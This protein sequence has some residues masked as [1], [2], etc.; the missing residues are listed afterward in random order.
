MPGEVLLVG[1]ATIAVAVAGF[2]AVTSTL[3]PPGGAWSQ[4]MRLRQRAIVSTSFNVAFEALA[5]LIAFAWLDDERS[6]FVVASYGVAVYATG[7][8]VWRGR[9]FIHA[10]GLRTGAAGLVLAAAGPTAALLF[11]ANAI[12]F[13]SLAV[14]ALALLVQLSVAIVSFYS[15]VSAASG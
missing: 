8:V 3:E 13:G 12:V 2:T 15:L 9:Q 4:A 6:A 1:I 10:G 5:P 11:W 7:I 14:F